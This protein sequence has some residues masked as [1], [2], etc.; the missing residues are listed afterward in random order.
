MGR[1]A[2]GPVKV[3]MPQYRGRPGLGMGV[4]GLG[5]RVTGEEIGDFPSIN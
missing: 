1:E 4:G 2:L 5:G 3:L